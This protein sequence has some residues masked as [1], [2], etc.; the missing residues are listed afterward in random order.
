MKPLVLQRQMSGVALITAILVVALATTAAIAMVSRQQFDVRRSANMLAMEQGLLYQQ[1]IEGWTMQI[2]RRDRKANDTDSLAD[3]WA[4]SL[5]PLPVEEGMIAG[6]INDLQGAFNLNTLWHDG[7]VDG[8]ALERF[9]RLMMIVGVEEF[10]ASSVVDWIDS[11]ID[12]T[13][14]D[15]AEDDHYL[16]TTIPHRSAN[17][18]MESR[19][20]LM[21]LARMSAKDYQ[22]LAPY[23]VTLP[24][25]TAIN[26][27]T[28]PK[29]ILRSLADGISESDAE[30][31]IAA[32]GEKGFMSVQ[33]F[34]SQQALAGRGVSP[35]G[36]NVASNYFSVNSRL[37]IGSIENGYSAMIFRNE[38]GDGVLV[39]R[40]QGEL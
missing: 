40:A 37:R 14:P 34:L 29:E 36:L 3:D 18:F 8:L 16:G 17:R 20:E 13:L 23:V 9:K 10:S 26:V 5:P 38:S 39:R 35:N 22:R 33:E 31:L 15:G 30:A 28:A 11:D 21:Q 32:R 1:G 12:P 25:A 2:L 27:N 7:K 19:S 4:I 6:R 24:T